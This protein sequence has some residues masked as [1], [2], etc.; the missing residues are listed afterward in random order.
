MDY[1]FALNHM[2][3]CMETYGEQ[4][5]HSSLHGIAWNPADYMVPCMELHRSLMNSIRVFQ[6]ISWGKVATMKLCHRE[7]LGVLVPFHTSL[8]TF[9]IQRNFCRRIPVTGNRH[10]HLQAG[11]VVVT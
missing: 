11:R 6:S 10:Y 9:S 1:G 7:L 2:I 5:C 8:V 4:D 3:P